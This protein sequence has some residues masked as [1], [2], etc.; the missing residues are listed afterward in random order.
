MG[1]QAPARQA[2]E[3]RGAQAR[4]ERPLAALA[5]RQHGVISRRQLLRGGL[6]PRTIGR[7]LEAGRLVVLHRGVYAFSPGRISQQGR[8]MAAV[9]ASGEGALLSHRSAATLW[10]LTRRSRGPV[11]VTSA[12]GRQRPGIAVHEGGVCEADRAVL[13]HIPVTTVARTLFDL[14]EVLDERALERAFEEASRLRLLELTALE[15]VCGRAHG[16]RALRPIRRLIEEAHG[17]AWTRSDLEDR[18]AA[19]C[20]EY[21]LPPAETNV[22]VLDYEVD[23]LWPRE[24]L[25]VEVDS[26]SFH[27]HREAFERD[28]A[29]DAAMQA[30][31]YRI[32]RVTHRRLERESATVA[33]ELRLLLNRAEGR[34]GRAGA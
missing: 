31:G 5:N 7:R 15:S 17:P 8:W 30:K 24:R 13:A 21:S 14:A 6:S 32:I 9:L 34:A 1:T 20:R 29:R 22:S 26:W 18:F 25:V 16:R 23:V 2:K 27:R 19:F 3:R 10:G 4:R 28:R 33:A 11:E 12:T